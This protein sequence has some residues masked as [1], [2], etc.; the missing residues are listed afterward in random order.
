MQRELTN[1]NSELITTYK[2]VKD[3]LPELIG[4]LKIYANNHSKEYYYNLRHFIK[5]LY[6]QINFNIVSIKASRVINSNIKNRG[7]I[8]ELIITSY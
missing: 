6:A 3:Y 5:E 2:C 8:H 7:T 4:L 1:I